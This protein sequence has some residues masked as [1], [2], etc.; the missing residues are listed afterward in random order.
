MTEELNGLI[1]V[2]GKSSR[3]GAA[4]EKWQFHVGGIPNYQRLY[5]LL[6]AYCGQVYISCRRD[7]LN[8]IQEKYP[9]IPDEKVN[10]GP[11]AGILSAMKTYPGKAWFVLAG[12]L[13]LISKQTLA[14]MTDHREAGFQALIAR[15]PMS[16]KIN[17][18][19]GIY[20]PTMIQAIENEIDHHK[21]S[22]RDLLHRSNV[23][24]IDLE[25]ND[26]LDADTP[27]QW[28][29]IQRMLDN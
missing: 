18:L 6:S 14:I 24:F 1:L 19:A 5:Q 2:G 23:K 16:K 8:Q 27:G 12:D 10:A 17:P 3:M 15:D 7:Q 20:E 21:G 29:L 13:F 4:T 28:Q 22:L 25:R 9:V 11:A 26:L